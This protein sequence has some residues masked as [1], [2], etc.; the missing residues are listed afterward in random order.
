M[1][2]AKK[3]SNQKEK[4]IE[5]EKVLVDFLNIEKKLLN[6]FDLKNFDFVSYIDVHSL[7]QS[8]FRDNYYTS[9]SFDILSVYFRNNKV[10]YSEAQSYSQ[11][12]LNLLM[13]PAIFLSTS[14]AV[15][16]LVVDDIIYG[17]LILAIVNGIITFLLTI[18]N[19]LKLNAE[20]ESHKMKSNEYGKLETQCI[21]LSGKLLYFEDDDKTQIEMIFNRMYKKLKEI[22]NSHTFMISFKIKRALPNTCNINIFERVKYILTT[23]NL[24]VFKIQNKINL[25]RDIY[26]KKNQSEDELSYIRKNIY[27]LIQKY[28]NIIKEYQKIQKDLDEEIETL[29]SKNCCSYYCCY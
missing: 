20:A 10:L 27:W 25:F 11:F 23:Q 14:A 28:M 8:Y 3:N 15:L 4:K 26:K 1:D 16:A 5:K 24:I 17:T 9:L 29:Y 12:K 7:L 2:E 22:E 19:Y 18:I 6:L 21:M 13:L